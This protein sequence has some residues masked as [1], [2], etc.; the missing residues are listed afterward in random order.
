MDFRPLSINVFKFLLLVLI[1]YTYV[2]LHSLECQCQHVQIHLYRSE[3]FIIFFGGDLLIA[4]INNAA[5]LDIF[6]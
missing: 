4:R 3:L 6:L 5:Q 2:F 1:I